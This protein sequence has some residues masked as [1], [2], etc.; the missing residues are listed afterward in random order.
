MGN[1]AV[2]ASDELIARGKDLIEKLTQ[3]GEKQSDA[4]ARMFN[5]VEE[6]ADGEVM[7]QSGI[8]VQALDSS[9]ANIRNMFLATVTGKEQIITEKDGK[10]AEIKEL[11]NK[12]EKDLRDKLDAADAEKRA[13]AEQAEAAAKAAALAIK[14][15]QAA[16]EQAETANRLASE[17]DRTIATLADK[18]SAAEAKIKGYDDL[19]QKEAAAQEQIRELHRTMEASKADHERAIAEAGRERAEAEKAAERELSAEKE[20]SKRAL[21]AAEKDHSAAIRELQAQMERKISDAEKDAALAMAN[22]VAEKER[23]F[24]TQLRTADKENAKLQARIEILEEQLRA[25]GTVNK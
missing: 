23:E 1:F 14:D 15:A 19:M 8:D 2:S 12:M 17:K 25:A 18:L 3:P 6:Q 21:A 22:A 4:L 13:A 7:R 24:A 20:A 11:K 9:L 5:I 10:I 16:K